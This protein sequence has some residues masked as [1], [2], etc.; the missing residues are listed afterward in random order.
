[1]IFL[2]ATAVKDRLIPI[3]TLP[4]IVNSYLQDADPFDPLA[5]P[6]YGDLCGLPPLFLQTAASEVLFSDSERFAKKA[7]NMHC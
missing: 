1:M 5:S 4:F 7:Q 3:K 6:L 2:N